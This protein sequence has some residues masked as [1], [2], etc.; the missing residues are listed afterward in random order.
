VRHRELVAVEVRL[1]AQRAARLE[2]AA[3]LD[4]AREKKEK[5]GMIKF[6]HE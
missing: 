2:D 1:Q 5:K 3:R 6:M 4:R